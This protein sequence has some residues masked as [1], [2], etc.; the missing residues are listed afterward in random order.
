[1]LTADAIVRADS[2][3]NCTK[4]FLTGV[5]FHILEYPKQSDAMRISA[6]AEIISVSLILTKSVEQHACIIIQKVISPM[7]RINISTFY[8]IIKYVFMCI[9]NYLTAFGGMK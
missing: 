7:K 4:A 5:N 9:N 3:T 6:A 8:V 1:M 2:V